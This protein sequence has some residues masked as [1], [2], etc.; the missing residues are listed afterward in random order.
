MKFELIYFWKPT[1]MRPIDRKGQPCR[2]LARGAKNSVLVE[3]EDGFKVITSKY[4]V[5]SLYAKRSVD[6]V[7][8]R[9]N[10]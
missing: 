4:A 8:R 2:I 1:P 5:R 6:E 3:F 10:H 7:G 9:A